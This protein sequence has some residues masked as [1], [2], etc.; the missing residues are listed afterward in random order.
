MFPF[1]QISSVLREAAATPL[2]PR[3]PVVICA[4]CS[5]VTDAPRVSPAGVNARK[6]P[7]CRSWHPVTRAGGAEPHRYPQREAAAIG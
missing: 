6:C 5:V 4:R 3:D 1:D 2:A 7:I